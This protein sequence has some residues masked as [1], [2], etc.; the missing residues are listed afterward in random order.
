M[1]EAQ[2]V[3]LNVP[4]EKVTEQFGTDATDEEWTPL[5]GA[6]GTPFDGRAKGEA[7]LLRIR[8]EDVDAGLLQRL[9]GGQLDLHADKRGIFVA[10]A[11]PSGDSYDAL[12]GGDGRWVVRGG[13]FS[14]V[15]QALGGGAEDGGENTDRGAA[16]DEERAEGA[17]DED[18]VEKLE[19][20]LKARDAKEAMAAQV[21]ASFGQ[22]DMGA[23]LDAEDGE[24]EEDPL[25]AAADARF[26]KSA[27]QRR[28][29]EDVK[30]ALEPS[31]IGGDAEDEGGSDTGGGARDGDEDDKANKPKEASSDD[32][33]EASATE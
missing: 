9:L 10:S 19:G 31:P 11:A 25:L 4:F 7:S 27:A 28:K 13:L 18:A 24:D 21:S 23:V 32:S 29:E 6:D 17:L 30:A 22:K 1:S 33:S 14:D 26:K 5:R 15:A 2:Y 20:A 8:E 12:V 16:D 3:V